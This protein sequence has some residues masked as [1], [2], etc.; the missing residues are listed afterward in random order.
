MLPKGGLSREQFSQL[1]L[2]YIGMAADIVEIFEAFRECK[3]MLETTLIY[4]V[5]AIWS[6]SLF[7]FCLVFRGAQ[8]GRKNRIS[9][10][11]ATDLQENNDRQKHFNFPFHNR[12]LLA[13]VGGNRSENKKIRRVNSLFMFY[14]RFDFGGKLKFFLNKV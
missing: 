1:M 10:I 6:W 7:Q 2:A 11:Y 3:V 8:R 13:I 14:G 9:S 4:A 12:I 5:L